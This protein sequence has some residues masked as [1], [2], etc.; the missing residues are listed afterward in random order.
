MELSTAGLFLPSHFLSDLWF[1]PCGPVTL[2]YYTEQFSVSW[3]G[4]CIALCQAFMTSGVL[5]SLNICCSSA[6]NILSTSCLRS[7]HLLRFVCLSQ[8]LWD[9]CLCSCCQRRL[10]PFSIFHIFCASFW[11]S[12][13][14]SLKAVYLSLSFS[15]Q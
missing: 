7:T 11:K 6:W 15:T 5:S 10:F 12:F 2:Y 14:Q 3:M 9:G 1:V 4:L 8:Y 13:K